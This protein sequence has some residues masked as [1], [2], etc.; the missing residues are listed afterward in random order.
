[1]KQLVLEKI[2]ISPFPPIN[3]RC[4]WIN[5]RSFMYWYNGAWRSVETEI[6]IAEDYIDEK[7]NE[8]V[9]EE[10]DKLVGNAPE[11]LDTI[12]ELA[13]YTEKHDAESAVM[14]ANIDSNTKAIKELEEK[15]AT[16]GG[17]SSEWDNFEA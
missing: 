8:V 12:D 2:V 17:I 13:K 3:K 5:G 6:D 14:D 7:V 11:N 10:V 15:I 16:G 4:L 1:M 9:S